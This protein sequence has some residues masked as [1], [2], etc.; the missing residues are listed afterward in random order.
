MGGALAVLDALAMSGYLPKR[1]KIT[2]IVFG[3]PRVGNQAFTNYA[4]NI[5]G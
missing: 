5:V 4:H 1:I 2:V 3:M